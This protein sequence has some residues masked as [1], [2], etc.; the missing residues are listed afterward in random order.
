ML[1]RLGKFGAFP[2][3]AK[4]TASVQRKAG[5]SKIH[6]VAGF[7]GLRFGLVLVF[8]ETSGNAACRIGQPFG[9]FEPR[10][11]FLVFLV[12]TVRMR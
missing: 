2:T 1:N 12:I 3:L 5:T 11:L 7:G 8:A 6:T 4:D 9:H 10:P